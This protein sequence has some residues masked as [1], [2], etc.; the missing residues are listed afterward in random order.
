[1]QPIELHANTENLYITPVQFQNLLSDL[2][3]DLFGE[4][5]A[6]LLGVAG[7]DVPEKEGE[8]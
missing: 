6:R 3:S 5:S 8:D 7:L 4:T 1:M 2:V